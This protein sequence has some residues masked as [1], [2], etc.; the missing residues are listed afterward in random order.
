MGKK[1]VI[2]VSVI[3][4]V[5]SIGV[6]GVMLYKDYQAG[7][8]L[9]EY[10]QFGMTKIEEV[11]SPKQEGNVIIS[12][13]LGYKFTIPEG[14]ELLEIG[15]AE[16]WNGNDSYIEF[17]IVNVEKQYALSV[18]MVP[19]DGDYYKDTN[20]EFDRKRLLE[21]IFKRRFVKFAKPLVIY[22]DFCGLPC[23]YYDGLTTQ[24]R[25][26][27]TNIYMAKYEYIAP[28]VDVAFMAFGAE[29]AADEIK[30]LFDYFEMLD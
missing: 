2:I 10:K 19:Q 24:T 11:I 26:D 29:E 13:Q 5:L 17:S 20:S 28:Y 23:G 6:L 3:L 22:K 18:M 8:G 14:F 4:F 12:G 16:A 25:S 30:K 7:E 27:G 15:S 9:F 21:E 1:I